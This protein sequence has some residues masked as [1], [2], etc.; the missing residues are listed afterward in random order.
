LRDAII[1]ANTDGVS[2]TDTIVLQAGKTYA[3][4]LQDDPMSE[5]DS[6]T[7][8]L[9]IHSTA[10]KLVIQGG[11]Q[12]GIGMSTIDAS[13]I[14]DRIFNIVDAGTEVVFE[15]VILQGGSADSNGVGAMDFDDGGAICSNGGILTFDHVVIQGNRSSAG[16]GIF[17]KAGSLKIL[18]GSLITGNEVTAGFYPR[19]AGGGIYA[20]GTN[21]DISNSVISDNGVTG[22]QGN[23]AFREGDGGGGDGQGGGLW[24]SN[25]QVSLTGVTFSANTATGGMGGAVVQDPTNTGDYTAVGGQGG[26]G[27]GGALFLAESTLTWSNTSLIG[28]SA[29]GGAGGVA[30]VDPIYAPG[31]GGPGGAGLGGG[32]YAAFGNSITTLA[33]GLVDGNH[34]TGGPGA[35]GA[36][37]EDGNLDSTGDVINNPS[38]GWDGGAGGMGRGGGLYFSLADGAIAPS[39]HLDTVTLHDNIAQAGDGGQG[40]QGGLQFQTSAQA[41]SG[42]RGGD[43]G[44]AQ[45]GGLYTDSVAVNLASTVAQLNQASAGQGGQGGLGG[46]G[47]DFGGQGGDGGDG[48]LASGGGLFLTSASATLTNDSLESNKAVGGQ[49]GGAGDGELAIVFDATIGGQGGQGGQGG[50]GLGGGIMATINSTLTCTGSTLDYNLAAA[51]NGGNGGAGGEPAGTGGDGGDAGLSTGGGLDVTYSTASLVNSTISINSLAGASGG[52]GGSGGPGDA[53]NVFQTGDY[54][55]D[56]LSPID[57]GAGIYIFK[58]KLQVRSTTIAF[59]TA[60]GG[61]GG[62]VFCSESNTIDAVNTLIAKNTAANAPDL[63]GTFTSSSNHNLLGIGDGSNLSAGVDA[64]GNHVG[65]T[66][67]PID[68]LLLPLGYY[69]GP[70]QTHALQ[71]NSPAIDQGNDSASPGSTDQRGFARIVGSHIDIG[72]VEWQGPSDEKAGTTVA[73]SPPIF[74][75]FFGPGAG[76]RFVG[77]LFADGHTRARLFPTPNLFIDFFGPSAGSRVV[78]DLFAFSGSGWTESPA[79]FLPGIPGRPGSFA[80]GFALQPGSWTATRQSRSHRPNTDLMLLAI[81][82]F[83]EDQASLSSAS[84]MHGV[85]H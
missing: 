6:T 47:M 77:D 14:N 29:V 26:Q 71:K 48:G 62:G 76:R 5:G 58:S 33:G 45:G 81:D 51:G 60:H 23:L 73:P 54:G 15:H 56:G 28:N 40:G 3:L 57:A 32:L 10:H 16:G 30:E 34:A 11:G 21:I 72:A 1:Q 83:F 75:D 43:G 22:G 38:A 36:D 35:P 53:N 78:G 67:H 41:V 42:G 27:Q 85:H 68:P 69:G 13:N 84:G 12:R 37:G 63:A 8:D 59:N 31:P 19:D 7:G 17:T 20:D 44:Q 82:E 2:G 39:V 46:P 64:K 55:S 50:D 18:D 52:L 79:E 66:A 9:D 24:A 65:S 61:S 80:V 49:G 4:T 25:A 70:T 74:I